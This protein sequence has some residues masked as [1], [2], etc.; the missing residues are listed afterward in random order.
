MA[1]KPNLLFIYTDEQRFDT[2][3][4]YGNNAVNMPN[5]NRLAGESVVFDR[6]YVTQPVCTPSR[7]SL[8]TGLYPHTNGCVENNIPLDSRI[9]CLPEM[10]PEKDYETAHFGKWH[11][12]DEIFPQH[13][14]KHWRSIEDSYRKHYSPGRNRGEKSTYHHFLVEHGFTPQNGDIFTRRESARLPEEYGKPAYLAGE[15]S[16]FISRNKDNPFILYV[17]FL[18]P[19]MPYFSPRDNQYK[20]EDIELPANFSDPP[21]SRH[22][23]KSRILQKAYE[24]QGFSGWKLGEES[25]WRRLIANY[26]G[27][28]SLVDTHTGKILDTLKE[29]GIEDETIIVFTSDHGDM[30][31]SHRLLAKMVMFEEA[32]RVPM[33]IRLPGG[34]NRGVIRGPVSQIDLVPTLLDFMGGN[35]PGELEGSS[36]RNVIEEEGERFLKDPVFLEWNGDETGVFSRRATGGRPLPAEI[37]GWLKGLGPPGKLETAVSDPLR[38][39]ITDDGW[40]LNYSSIGEHELFNLKTDPCENQNL[41]GFN[42][43]SSVENKLREKILEWQEKTSDRQNPVFL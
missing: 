40:K 28:C 30:M 2:L 41:A 26:W 21:G 20:P 25:E 23:L 19:H 4:I 8:L 5:L 42:E 17:N 27:L 9:P 35:I 39:V 13:G 3:G 37:P 7:S 10:L 12:G 31:G 11:L 43:Y 33:M 38:T 14:F 34:R 36:R 18:E 6:A 22:H 1:K 32:I 15:A 29:C 16:K 24:E